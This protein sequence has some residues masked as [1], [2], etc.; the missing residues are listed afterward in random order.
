MK[1][2]K[3]YPYES[4]PLPKGWRQ[5][6]ERAACIIEQRG[7]CRGKLMNGAGNVCMIGAVGLAI[8]VTVK[9][10]QVSFGRGEPE[11]LQK[12]RDKIQ[13]TTRCYVEEWNDQRALN[14]QVVVAKLRE[15]ARAKTLKS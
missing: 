3:T 9:P 8:G 11:R 6:M 7:W 15:I 2:R 13:E 10:G 12:L 1:K 5:A 4:Y 14:R